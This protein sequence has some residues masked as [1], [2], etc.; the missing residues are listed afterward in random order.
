MLIGFLVSSSMSV[1]QAQLYRLTEHLLRKANL[2][3]I[4]RTAETELAVAD[5]INI[6][7]EVANRSSSK[8]VY[9]NLCAQE[10]LHRSENG[11][12]SASR[13]PE[14]DSLLPSA[15]P[16]DRSEQCENEPSTNIVIEEALKKAGLLSDS[17]P[18]SPDQSMAIQPGEGEPSTNIRE[19]GPEDVFEIDDCPDLDIYGEFEYN[20]DDED[21]I[22]VSAA[23]V[24]KVQ[25]EEGTS[26]MKVVLSSLH[27]ERSSDTL[28]LEKRENLGNAEV[29]N[30]SS[31][32]PEKH[33]G[34]GFS[35]ST[36]EDGTENPCAP[37]ETLFGEEGEELSVA[38]CEEL[39]GPD[40]EPLM[41]KFPEAASVKPYGLI[42]AEAFAG[43]GH[44]ESRE[45]GVQN[46]ET[47]VSELG[48]ESN[49]EKNVSVG[50]NSSAGESSPNHSE[51]GKKVRQKE[52]KSNADT[53]KRSDNSI[54]KK[55]KPHRFHYLL[56]F[57]MLVLTSMFSFCC[58]R[59]FL[60]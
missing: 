1:I 40:K 22:G 49:T 7:K 9:L 43:N 2:P 6:E 20:L 46:Q 60:V 5:A 24:S 55:V 36:M 18:N 51:L 25:P 48:N 54:F 31:C 10:I 8:P 57:L 17:P 38:E 26:K 47:K 45:S 29:P 42:D 39:Y 30:D 53:T 28:D 32:I 52:K 15:V 50:H 11:K 14:I 19:E 35:N 23:K 44:S 16:A 59:L 27:S 37:Q 3:V 58:P 34:V 41:K 12:S 21:Y 13:A 56:F 33:S 4:R